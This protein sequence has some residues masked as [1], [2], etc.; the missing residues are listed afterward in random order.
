MGKRLSDLSNAANAV[1]KLAKSDK[2]PGKI[3]YKLGPFR[4]RFKEIMTDVSNF[5]NGLIQELG[6]TFG[7]SPLTLIHPKQDVKNFKIYLDRREEFFKSEDDI[8]I[9][10]PM[11]TF[12][13]LEPANLSIDD[14]QVLQD[15]GLLEPYEEETKDKE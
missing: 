1:E 7:G 6:L 15:I 8:D 13:D 3:R 5:E 9:D 4:R 12:D 14:E 11:F 10:I 2:L